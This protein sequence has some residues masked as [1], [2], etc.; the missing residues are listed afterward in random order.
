MRKPPVLLALALAVA[1]SVPA[2]AGDNDLVFSRIGTVRTDGAGNPIGVIPSNVAFR[3]VASELGVVMAPRLLAPA[4][5]LGFGGF[6]FSVDI[7]YTSISSDQP[8]W[9]VLASSPDPV[10]AAEHGDMLM[11][12]LGIFMRKGMWLPL[13]S[14]EVGLGAVHLQD[15]QLWAAQGYMKFALHEGFHDLPV[16]SA[17]VRAGVSRVMGSDQID[18][19]ITSLDVSLSKDF[20]FQSSVTLSP[21][22]GYNLLI[23]IPRSE[24]LDATPQIDPLESSSDLNMSFAFKDQVDI[25]RHR[26]FGGLKLQYYVF[27]I[28]FEA[29]VALAGSSVDDRAGTDDQCMD[30]ATTTS[31]DSTDQSGTQET[32]IL[33]VGLDF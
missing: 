29:S 15:S 30:P 8:F 25:L 5:T 17:A 33:S 10:N 16:P 14:F 1:G 19:T 23:I 13:P 32:Y 21:Y 31:C 22:G 9:R 24:V 12:T 18:L 27:A 7:G 2:W 6:Q 4:D 20:G 28:T 11:P 3:S 26:F